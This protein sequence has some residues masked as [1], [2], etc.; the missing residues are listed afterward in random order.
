MGNW[1]DREFKVFDLFRDRWALVTAGTM[2]RFNTCTVGWG[3]LGTLWTR[4][5][6]SGSVATV[7]LYET[8]YTREFLTENDRFT[9]SFFPPQ[10]KKA[11]GILGTLSGREGDK[12]AVAG[13][14]PLAI[15][16][17]VGFREAELT[18]V[19]RKLYQHRMTKED[20]AP[21]VQAY[22]AGNPK[23][24]PPVENGVWQPHWV[25]VG[26]ILDAVNDL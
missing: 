8:R 23:A 4:P 3:S 7:Y 10:N 5:G 6:K 1:E 18:F 20:L 11:L 14:T 26:E 13:L 12:V 22:Y 9:L 25:F 19:C 21:D 24:F 2:E 16:G 17:S 15:G